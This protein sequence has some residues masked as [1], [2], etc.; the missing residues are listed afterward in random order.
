MQFYYHTKAWIKN[1]SRVYGAD[2]VY[3]YVAIALICMAFVGLW[4][5]MFVENEQG[6]VTQSANLW[7]DWVV[8]LSYT[9]VY[10]EWPLGKALTESP[11]LHNE[12]FQYPPLPNLLSAI[13]VALGIPI[14][15][16]MVLTSLIAN[17]LTAVAA[18]LLYRRLSIPTSLAIVGAVLFFFNGGLG[19]LHLL[20]GEESEL[21]T[22]IAG[23]GIIIQNFVISEFVPQKAISTA[24]PF[25]LL[26]VFILHGALADISQALSSF[27][28]VALTIALLTF[29]SAM[30]LLSSMHTFLCLI[31]VSVSYALFHLKRLKWLIALLVAGAVINGVIYFSY[32]GQNDTSGFIKWAPLELANSS[33]LSP[34]AYFFWNYGLFVPLAIIGMLTTRAYRNPLAIAGVLIF[35]IAHLMQFQPWIWDNSK[36]VTWGYCF[37]IVPILF[38]FNRLSQKGYKQSL[39]DMLVAS[40]V[41][42][43]AY[44]IWQ[45]A[46]PSAPSYTLFTK[47]DIALARE[48]RELTNPESVTLIYS[49]HN[50]WVHALAGRQVLNAFSGWMWSYGKD[51]EMLEARR[52]RLIQEGE[53]ALREE[54]I[55]YVVI[56]RRHRPKKDLGALKDL[57]D[58]ISDRR[59]LIKRVPQG[60]SY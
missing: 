5:G 14:T 29:L 16:A 43:G 21:A 2:R 50:N 26:Y 17:I 10:V 4:S 25:F 41:F 30:V 1:Q 38:L 51:T 44:D 45:V 46:R 34:L 7:A 55:D 56:D 36:L 6:Y 12:P 31:I 23:K 18:I 13:L 52:D 39:R 9:N 28:R 22:N 8:H 37:L 33:S 49:G 42:A 40:L 32:Y 35:A 48:F 54:G 53:P 11:L 20:N 57:P 59:Y 58:L 60:K 15:L 27:K 19:W 24:A 3:L 47:K